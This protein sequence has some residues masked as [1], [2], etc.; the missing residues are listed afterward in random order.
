MQR[1]NVG[2]IEGGEHFR[3]TL[4]SCDA[5]RIGSEGLGQ[6][7][8]RDRAAESLIPCEIDFAHAARAEA[9]LDLVLSKG[10]ADHQIRLD[11]KSGPD[12]SF[13]IFLKKW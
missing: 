4:E 7:L 8:H 13:T 12:R 3:F 2:M 1:G 10:F 6:D 5:F 11:R 9:A